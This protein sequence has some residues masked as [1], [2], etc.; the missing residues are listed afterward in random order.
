VTAHQLPPARRRDCFVLIASG[1]DDVFLQLGT[2]TAIRSLRRTNPSVP[3][4]VL[5]HDLSPNQQRLFTD[6]VLVKV[7]LGDFDFSTHSTFMRPD[8]PKTTFLTL[9]LEQLEQF[10]VAVYVDADVVV[11]ASLDEVFNV[12]APLAARIMDDHPLAEHF[13]KGREVLASEGIDSPHALNN[14]LLRVDLRYWRTE[15][16]LNQALG[17]YHRHG[18]E[19]FRY[20]D[21][22]LLNLIAF[23]TPGFAPLPRTYN[24]CRYPDMLRKEHSFTTNTL[25]LIAPRIGD[26]VV[27]VVHWTGPLK[28]WSA[29][30]RDLQEPRF[31]MC[32]DCYDQFRG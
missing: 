16:L 23:K 11:L 10:D 3:I 24:F 5:H 4:V 27:K 14:G 1:Q 28:P 29:G 12:D 32:L 13:E 19:A 30:V 22:S 15:G 8:I 25:G 9:Q 26:G 18:P 21:Q 31:E 7:P 2:L 17:L 6:A 20:S